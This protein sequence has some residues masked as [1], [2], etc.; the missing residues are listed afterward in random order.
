MIELLING[1]PMPV[2]SEATLKDLLEQLELG[3]RRLAVE[4]NETVVPRSLYRDVRL[5]PGDRIEI[6]HAIGGG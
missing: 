2:H 4:L 1:D 3:N 6:V 5:Q